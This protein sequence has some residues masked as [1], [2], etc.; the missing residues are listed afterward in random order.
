MKRYTVRIPQLVQ[1]QI[2][3]QVLYIAN[4]SIPKR[5]MGTTPRDAINSIGHLPGHAVDEEASARAGEKIRK[6]VFERTYLIHYRINAS[7]SAIDMMNFRHG[8]RLPRKN[9]P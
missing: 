2:L 9:E 7:D 5:E 4:G 6:L 3:E 1:D 8:A